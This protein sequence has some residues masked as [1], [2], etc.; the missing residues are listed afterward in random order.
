MTIFVR[1]GISGDSARMK[2]SAPGAD[3]NKLKVK[4]DE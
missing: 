2:I 3:T 1:L 4:Y